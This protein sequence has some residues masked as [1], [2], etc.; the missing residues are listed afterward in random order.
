MVAVETGLVEW[1]ILSCLATHKYVAQQA[2]RG[3]MV[4]INPHN[5]ASVYKLTYPM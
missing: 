1:L 2:I 4:R 3:G 5:Q